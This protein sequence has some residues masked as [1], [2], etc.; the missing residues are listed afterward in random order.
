[1]SMMSEAHHPAGEMAGDPAG[2]MAGDPAGEMPH[3]PQPCCALRDAV[4]KLEGR[5][6]SGSSQNGVLPEDIAPLCRFLKHCEKTYHEWVL[7]GGASEPLWLPECGDCRGDMR[8]CLGRMISY[9]VEHTGLSKRDPGDTHQRRVYAREVDRSPAWSWD[10]P[11][12]NDYTQYA[13][14]EIVGLFGRLELPALWL[15]GAIRSVAASRSNIR[16]MEAL[17]RRA[18]ELFGIPAEVL[19]TDAVSSLRH[20]VPADRTH[21]EA[22]S[23]DDDTSGSDDDGT[24]DDDDEDDDE[25]VSTKEERLAGFVRKCERMLGLLLGLPG[26]HSAAVAVLRTR[27]SDFDAMARALGFS[28]VYHGELDKAGVVADR[29]RERLPRYRVD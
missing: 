23:G 17:V 29:L 18:K 7:A 10:G 14:D 16:L 4:N 12:H 27:D 21:P 6:G 28:A 3:G 1:M 19:V 24:D 13:I 20:V 5:D 26:V 8:K 22:E 9:L 25:F 11:R 2:E 15:G